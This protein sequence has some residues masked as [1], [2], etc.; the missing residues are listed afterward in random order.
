ME[1]G[2]ERDRVSD[3][4]STC[5]TLWYRDSM[6]MPSSGQHVSPS[7]LLSRVLPLSL[8]VWH[9][10]S[11][12]PVQHQWCSGSPCCPH[13]HYPEGPAVRRGWSQHQWG[14][15]QART[16]KP[17][18]LLPSLL[19]PLQLV[20][21][22]CSVGWD[23]VWRAAHW[24]PVPDR[25]GDAG[26]SSNAAAGL[27]GQDGPT[28]GCRFGTSVCHWRQHHRQRQERREYCQRGGERSPRLSK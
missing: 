9:R 28:A 16:V 18:L 20:T 10:E 19:F 5:C 12:Q 25:C 8:Y 14:W 23:I 11:H 22:P 15:A 26:R 24:V 2:D 13:Q 6:P 27:P 3:K 21:S 17:L 7:L 1:T 4:A